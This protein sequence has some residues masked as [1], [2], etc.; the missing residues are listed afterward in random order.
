MEGG[1]QY[2]HGYFYCHNQFGYGCPI[3]LDLEDVGAIFKYRLERG[4][5][6]M[7]PEST[8]VNDKTF[9]LIIRG[10]PSG[11]EYRIKHYAKCVLYSN[12][13]FHIH[14]SQYETRNKL[15]DD[16]QEAVAQSHEK[17]VANG[18]CDI[19]LR[20]C[21]GLYKKGGRGSPLG[22]G[23]H[24]DDSDD[25]SEEG[26]DDDD[27]DSD[28][29][30]QHYLRSSWE[31]VAWNGCQPKCATTA[32]AAGAAAAAAA[33][34]IDTVDSTTVAHCSNDDV[35]PSSSSSQA[36]AKEEEG[37]KVERARA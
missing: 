15:R 33:A 30:S 28:D 1:A 36:K 16:I 35:S 3:D 26:A 14:G 6:W 11:P 24:F 7:E 20:S 21:C 4:L 27:E 8:L 25:D 9:C 19:R 13:M 29:D 32:A 22:I 23:Q 10:Q 2:V 17:N 18:N 37:G 34:A 5:T 12:G 31:D